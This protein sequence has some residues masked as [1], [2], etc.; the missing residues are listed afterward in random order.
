MIV[1]DGSHS[2]WVHVDSGDT[3]GTVLRPL[4]FLLFINDLPCN[5]TSSVRLF[6]DDCILYR[7]VEKLDDSE[8]LQQDLDTL[9][10]WEKTWQ[11]EFN[12]GNTDISCPGRGAR[13]ILSDYSLKWDSLAIGRSTV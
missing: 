11:M 2:E 6:A 10:K 8:K 5:I 7:T 9:C 1:V 4:L 12:T 13:L 3:Q